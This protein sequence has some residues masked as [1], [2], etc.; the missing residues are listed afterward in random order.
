VTDKGD[1]VPTD[2]E[3]NLAVYGEGV[4]RKNIMAKNTKKTKANSMT[5]VEKKGYSQLGVRGGRA[6]LKKHGKKHM[7]KIGAAGARKRWGI[8]K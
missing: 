8:K 3:P 5:S 1:V 4:Y 6:T 7:A 2:P